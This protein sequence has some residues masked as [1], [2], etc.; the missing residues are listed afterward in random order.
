M[1]CQDCGSKPATHL[2]PHPICD[3][4]WVSRFSTQRIDGE[5][6]PFRDV[7]KARLQGLNLWRIEGESDKDWGARC[8]KYSINSQERR[9]FK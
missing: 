9:L 5:D 3:R 7:H 6:I 2:T 4:C 8:Q 1:N